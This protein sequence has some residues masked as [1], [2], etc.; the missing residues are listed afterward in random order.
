[1]LTK[2]GDLEHFE[3]K[4]KAPGRILYMLAAS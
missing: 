1:M 2:A 3:K 4:K